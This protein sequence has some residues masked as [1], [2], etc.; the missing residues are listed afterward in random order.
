MPLIPESELDIR[1]ALASGPGGQ[2]VNKRSTKAVL[3]WNV[4]ESV[5]F[6]DVQKEKIRA[7]AGHRL[8][9][10]DEI[11]ISAEDERS[12][13]QNKESVISRLQELVDVALT[14]VKVRKPTKPTRAQ[15]AKRVDDKVRLGQKK[16]SRRKN[17][18]P[19]E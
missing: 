2:N 1:F 10:E 17:I 3:H 18:D 7:A 16:I 9:K 15:K 13:E 19:N 14:P 4:G 6:T 8:S 11:V 5:V 12:Q